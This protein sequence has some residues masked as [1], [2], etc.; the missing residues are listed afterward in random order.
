MATAIPSMKLLNSL[1]KAE[2]GEVAAEILPAAL[3]K[4]LLGKKSGKAL[5]IG[6]LD[7][8]RGVLPTGKGKRKTSAAKPYADDVR[9]ESS[10]YKGHPMGAVRI[11][12]ADNGDEPEPRAWGCWVSMTIEKW[13]WLA[14]HW[15]ALSAE[16]NS[17]A[18]A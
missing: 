5:L 18:S 15:D 8:Q 11:R 16:I 7:L 1:T 6:E 14:E 4:T 17:A 10:T 13:A 9:F 2:V 3:V 12:M